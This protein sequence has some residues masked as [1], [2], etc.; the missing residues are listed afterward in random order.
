MNKKTKTPK[1]PETKAKKESTVQ[2][3]LFFKKSQKRLLE[4]LTKKHARELNDVLNEILEDENLMDKVK[5]ADRAELLPGSEGLLLLKK[6]PT[7]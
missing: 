4:E 1:V 2:E 7:K 3:K 5:N 6:A